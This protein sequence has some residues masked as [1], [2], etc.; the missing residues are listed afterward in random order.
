[1]TG[2]KNDQTPGRILSERDRLRMEIGL[3][4]RRERTLWNMTQE[5]LSSLLGISSNYLGQLE[6]GTRDLSLKIEDRLCELFNLSH[7]DFRSDLDYAEWTCDLAESGGIFHHLSE[8]DLMRLLRSCTT[9]ELQ[10][11]GHILRSTLHYLRSS[12]TAAAQ[13]D[14]PGQAVHREHPVQTTE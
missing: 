3:R 14:Q 1:M 7:A 13:A 6:R 12:R 8:Q 2:K 10:F 11:C 9:E 5:E 4:I